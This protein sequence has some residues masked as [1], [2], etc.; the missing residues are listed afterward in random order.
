MKL[1]TAR[2][3]F[4]VGVA[5]VTGILAVLVR[6]G[7]QQYVEIQN[8]DCKANQTCTSGCFVEIENGNKYYF[9]CK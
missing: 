1:V 2:T 9:C 4:L 3:V 8:A 6:A 7:A 5:V